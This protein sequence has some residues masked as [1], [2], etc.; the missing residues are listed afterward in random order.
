MK[1]AVDSSALIRLAWRD[2]KSDEVLDAFRTLERASL[3]VSD[4]ILLEVETAIRAKSF[5]EK[6]GLARKFHSTVDL[7]MK[8]AFSRLRT[9][10]ERGVVVRLEIDWPE[11]MSAA[12]KL[13][14]RWAESH[15]AR[16]MD[17]LHLSF[18]LAKKCNGFFTCDERQAVI[19]RGEG[20]KVVAA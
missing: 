19:A 6:S 13:A 20:L 1:V 3:M 18:A 14:R 16:T 4:L 12:Q 2:D 9:L 10:Q 8:A 5:I 17:I 15:G 7:S 11:W